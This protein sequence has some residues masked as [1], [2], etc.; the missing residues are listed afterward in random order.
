MTVKRNTE[1]VNLTKKA[2]EQLMPGEKRLTVYDTHVHGL[3]VLV[4]PTGHK[5]F[6]WFRK[7]RGVGEWKTLGD[8]PSLTVEQARTKAQERNAKLARWKSDDYDGVNPLERKPNLTLGDVLEHYLEHHLKK[9]STNPD[10]AVKGARWQFDCYLTGWRNRRIGS[11]QRSDV[12][13]LHTEVAEKNGAVTANRLV[14]FLRTLFYHAEN[15]LS[16]A[17]VNPAKN[18]RRNKITTKEAPRRRHLQDDEFPKFF[19]AWHK[20]T[21]RDLRDFVLLGLVTG[22][23]SGDVMAMRWD[24][25]DLKAER[26]TVPNRKKPDNP[27]VA[28]LMPELI[29]LLKE[30]RPLVTR[31]SPW[32]FPGRGKMGHITTFK[33]GWKSLLKRAKITSL[34]IHDLRRTLA[35]LQAK[36]GTSLKIIGESLGHKSIEA[37]DI[38]SQLQP[39]EARPSV[40]QATR[41]MLALAKTKL[42]PARGL[43]RG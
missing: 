19:K 36:Q 18:P 40:E 23:R 1:R 38:Y 31:D 8:F 26:W 4:Q 15:K 37:T 7:V 21:N 2:I 28:A 10:K 11:I 5:S 25:L 30:R 14:T 13:S 32:V 6:F 17:G 16:W 43:P 12:E 27:Y 3:G 35:S 22:A 34:T 42:K 9:H 20:E 24:Q 39:G 33:K 29:R 41:S